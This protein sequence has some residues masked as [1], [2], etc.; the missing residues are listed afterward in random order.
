VRGSAKTFA[1]VQ[2]AL[3]QAGI[4]FI[5]QHENKGPGVRLRDPVG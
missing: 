5:D 1:R 2:R 4:E 3:E